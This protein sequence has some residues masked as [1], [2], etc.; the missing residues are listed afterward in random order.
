M[1]VKEYTVLFDN[2]WIKAAYLYRILSYVYIDDFMKK[3]EE[4]MIFSF[5][6]KQAHFISIII[7]YIVPVES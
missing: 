7:V 5:K 4:E 2:L 1:N 3:K 6:K